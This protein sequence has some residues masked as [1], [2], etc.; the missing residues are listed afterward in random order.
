MINKALTVT[1]ANDLVQSS[2]FLTLNERRLIE[3]A[4]AKI[5][6]GEVIPAEIKITAAE[7]AG[8]W[9]L[10][11]S[12]SFRELDMAAKNLYER[13]I[14][15][16]R[17]DNGEKWDVRWLDAKANYKHGEGYV[18]L[19]FSNRI[20]PYLQQLNKNFTRYKLLEIRHLRSAYSIRLYE[21]IM[22]YR[23]TGFRTN[24]LEE[25]KDYFGVSEKYEK[26]ADF[27]RY[28][29]SKSIKELNKAT[30]YEVT[31]EIERRGRN[32]HRVKLFFSLKNQLNLD[33]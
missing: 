31:M 2:Y 12:Q 11:A 8:A 7:F 16:N 3:C 17:L 19:S 9:D 27:N 32:V 33:L 14:K 20:K 28:V 13:S 6:N 24:T 18:I 22:Q 10:P 21:L 26:W 25:L 5:Q 15:I 29:L 23:A 30:A 4:T 1:R